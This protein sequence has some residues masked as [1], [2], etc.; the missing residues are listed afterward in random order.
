MRNPW[1]LEYS[2]FRP[3]QKPPSRRSTRKSTGKGEWPASPPE[4]VRGRSLLWLLRMLL[5]A[6]LLAHFISTGYWP[7]PELCMALGVSLELAEDVAPET[8]APALARWLAELEAAPEVAPD[9]VSQNIGWLAE[10]L[11]L[12]PIA[13][14]LLSLFVTAEADPAFEEC[15]NMSR[16]AMQE[17]LYPVLA[18]I[19]EAEPE[20]VRAALGPHAPLLELGLVTR[21]DRPFQSALSLGCP[22][23]ITAKLSAEHE[24]PDA[25]LAAFFGPAAPTA[26]TVEDFPHVA[27]E[28]DLARRL[29]EGATAKRSCGV[30]VLIYG[31]PGTGKTVLARVLS[32]AIGAHLFE[33]APCGDR[34]KASANSSARFESYALVQRF[35]REAPGTILLFDELEDV[36]P[37]PTIWNLGDRG[38]HTGRKAWINRL[39]ET[40]PVPTIWISNSLAR[41]DPAFRRRFDLV[42]E[43]GTPST[44][45]RHRIIESEVAGLPVSTAWID[46]TSRDDRVRPAT[47][48][49]AV[50]VARIVGVS[51]REDAEA[52]LSLSIGG[53]L[54]AEGLHE[55]PRLAPNDACGYDVSFVNASVDVDALVAG[56]SR[57]RRAAIVFH[58]LPGTGKSALAAHLA[59]RLGMPLLVKRASDVLDP[60]VGGTEQNLA[61]MFREA[62]KANALLF[63]DEAD[64]F[65]QERRGAHR[66]WEVTQVNELLVQMETFEGIF[67]CATNLLER[68]DAAAFRRF[69]LK[70]RFE[71]LRPEQR[72]RM[73]LATL[74]GLGAS[75]ERVPAGLAPLSALVPGDFAAVA[76]RL[77]IIGGE[78][79]AER[80]LDELADELASRGTQPVS[81]GFRS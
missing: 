35:L 51:R 8:V 28:L 39:L 53:A 81:I 54:L 59:E 24:S 16:V 29:L 41:L 11:G 17:R 67:V 19:V 69:A 80:L 52:V 6:D 25:L 63:L 47:I 44:R 65:L 31:P 21:T 12:D 38:D 34:G 30:N 7:N 5:R 64:S 66:N 4:E 23:E 46:A 2:T 77:R 1:G 43:L 60:Y 76:R 50:R 22:D 75:A 18:Q 62:K 9:P 55:S 48:A 74:E 73:F 79:D 33:V 3:L 27:R 61:S 78:V 58:G 36:F 32:D 26:L 40:N 10:R 68:L 57:T 70:V 56:L 42:L 15:F 45:V 37:P 49:R 13:R 14:E 72:E 71:P 20:Q